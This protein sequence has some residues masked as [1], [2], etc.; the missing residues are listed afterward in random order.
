M[1]EALPKNHSSSN[2]AGLWFQNRGLFSDHF[3]KARLPQ[4][5][6]WEIDLELS[7]FRKA[8]LSLYVNRQHQWAPSGKKIMDT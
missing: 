2:E 1:P 5:K 4:W 6:E 3:L 7:T 8:L